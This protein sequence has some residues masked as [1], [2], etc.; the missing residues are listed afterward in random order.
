MIRVFASIA[1][2]V[3]AA[4]L[5]A[6]S[7]SAADLTVL[8]KTTG[9]RPGATTSYLT[10]DKIRMAQPDGTEILIDGP[11][12]DFTM[13]DNGKKEYSV[14]TKAQFEAA[15]VQMA[16]KMQQAQE[17]MKAAQAKMEAQMKNMPPEMR[18]KLKAMQAGGLG[19]MMTQMIDVKKGSGRRTIAGYG[20]D[21]WIISIGEMSKTEEC[22]ST[23]VPFPVQA[24][25]S[26]RDIAQAFKTSGPMAQGMSDMQEKMKDLKG[27]PL[28]RATTTNILGKTKTETTEVTEIKKGVPANAFEIPAGYKKVESPI[29]KA[30]SSM[31]K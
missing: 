12:G 28:A 1:A 17:Q 8:A 13:I 27:F 18:E 29:V 6:G 9:D 16:Q 7:A 5:L 24:W 11:S 23:E 14:T 19:G 21:N 30:A 25:Q 2:G 31:K 15:A 22:L 20:C 26:Y 4:T 10:A 3:A